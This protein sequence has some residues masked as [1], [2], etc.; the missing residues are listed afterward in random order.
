[1]TAKNLLHSI[2]ARPHRTPAGWPSFQRLA[3]LWLLALCLWLPGVSAKAAETV[4]ANFGGSSLTIV[5]L[6]TGDRT[7]LVTTNAAGVNLLADPVGVAREANGNLII[8]EDGGSRLIRINPV[9]GL[10]TILSSGSVGAGPAMSSIYGL[11]VE[12]GGHIIVGSSGNQSILRV[13]PVT[14]D[15]T[16][17]ASS[18]VG[19]GVAMVT[20]F[21][22]TIDT[23]GSI[24][25][26][27]WTGSEV[28]R[29]DPATGVRTH[30]SSSSV[31]SGPSLSAPT[32]VLRLPDGDYAALNNFDNN[33]VLRID[34]VT[35]DRTLISGAT[36][37]DGPAIGSRYSMALADDGNLYVADFGYNR[38]VRVDVATGDRTI[39]SAVGV[40]DGPAFSSPLGMLGG[41]V[42]SIIPTEGVM[43]LAG[44]EL[45]GT[46]YTSGE[47]YFYD[48]NDTP[49][50]IQLSNSSLNQSG[51]ENTTVG[52]LTTT[53]A[54]E[55]DTHLYSLV[56]GDGD[57]DNAS[58]NVFENS[59]RANDASA[60][61]AGE[62]SVRIRTADNDEATF[63]KAFAITVVDDVAP[64]I[65]SAATAGGTYGSAFAY[66]ISA[67]GGAVSFNATGLPTGLSV[68]TGNGEI[69]GSPT[70]TGV[71]DVE[72][73]A[74]D[75]ATNTDT[76]ALEITIA[77]APASIELA[78]LEPT[79]NGTA[80]AV[81]ASTTPDGLS[82]SFTYDG[83][84]APPTA[85]G[86]YAVVATISDDNFGGTANGTLLI[87]KAALI[88]TADDVS[89]AYGASNPEFTGSLNGAIEGDNLSV[90]YSTSATETSA[91]GTYDI[92][93]AITDP[94]EKLGNYAVTLNNGTLTVDKAVIVATADAQSRAYGAANPELTIS[95][96]GFVNDET[97]EALDELPVA[98]TEAT[99][100]SVVNDYA[101]TLNGGL[102]GNYSFD[103][104][105]GTLTITPAAL[106]ATAEDAS[107]AYGA[108]NPEFTGSLNGAIEG[109][110]LSVGYTTIA[111]ETSAVGTYDIVP[112]ITDPDEKLGNYAV[113]LNNGTLTVDKAV[114]MATADDQS[115]AYGAANPELTISYAGFVNEET[116]EVL[117]ELPVAATEA[118]TAS[119]VDDYAI[120]LSGGL[121]GNYAFDLVAG[122][123]TV[124][125]AALIATAEDASRA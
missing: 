119:A 55:S 28:V 87:G 69:T 84:I 23:D 104:V 4:V 123:L 78:G 63:E 108:S 40:G 31:G 116:V 56:V 2:T 60:L 12:A 39:V 8:G 97:V 64:V 98:A 106:I 110:N 13:D 109:D 17:L 105:A 93:P 81:S 99:S 16:V 5:N 10:Q 103:L 38:I 46:P 71:F 3:G 100:A 72:L 35:G 65:A 79:Y 115:R 50:D 88:A 101:I 91:V 118:T 76:Q 43:D 52:T 32:A 70:Q 11:A 124:T 37:G 94:D 121:D 7:L 19:S 86:S 21:G 30:L 34:D 53:D 74:A 42:S 9:T 117:D 58:F 41:A 54:D 26:P 95:Y 29:L 89:R 112:A 111:T 62:Y 18:S 125:P 122:T 22:V 24:L 90:G 107:R 61:A 75:A 92:V 36:R 82:V 77:K 80:K 14:G 51:G 25:L 66:T 68:N 102:D 6:V 67:T 59:L 113:T 20:P 47:T 49:T 33:Y 44:N 15:R 114:I 45:T 96:A 57:T 48:P 1:M 85:A 83:E 73:S 27:N 120:T